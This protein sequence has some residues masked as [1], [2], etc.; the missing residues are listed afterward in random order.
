MQKVIVDNLIFP[1]GNID[2]GLEM[3]TYLIYFLLQEALVQNLPS[4]RS[5][6]VR[7][8][9]KNLGGRWRRLVKKKPPTE[10]YT[11]PPEL[12]PQLKQIYVY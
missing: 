12:K 9:R 11:I 6:F 10:V 1:F 7:G 3:H 4:E 2:I 5:G 8:F